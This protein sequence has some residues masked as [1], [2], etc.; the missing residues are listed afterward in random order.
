M[1][2][3]AAGS[4]NHALLSHPHHH[5]ILI[6]RTTAAPVDTITLTYTGRHPE[7]LIVT[8]FAQILAGLRSVRNNFIQLTN[9]PFPQTRYVLFSFHSGARISRMPSLLRILISPAVSPHKREGRTRGEE[10]RV[11]AGIWIT[12]WTVS[13]CVDVDVRLVIA[14]LTC[15]CSPIATTKSE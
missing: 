3:P 5:S 4:S 10:T 7:E 9:V 2:A 13:P 15:I 6:K 12:L 8:P 14:P 11:T 1:L